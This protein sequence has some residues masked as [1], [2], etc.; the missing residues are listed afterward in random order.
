MAEPATQHRAPPRGKQTVTDHGHI[1]DPDLVCSCTVTWR[2]QQR[3]PVECLHAEHHA[4]RQCAQSRKGRKQR[5]WRSQTRKTGSNNDIISAHY[6]L[7]SEVILRAWADLE[8][9]ADVESALS[10]FR[11]SRFEWWSGG[12][13][14]L[15]AARERAERIGAA[16]RSRRQVARLHNK[17]A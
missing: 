10:F 12:V 1:F 17:G 6:R 16:T 5:G 9:F 4:K 14:D 2:S 7:R 13:A 8:I 11:S 15:V 3:N